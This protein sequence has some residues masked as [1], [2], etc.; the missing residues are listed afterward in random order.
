MEEILTPAQ[1]NPET[2]SAAGK[3]LQHG[4]T[5]ILHARGGHGGSWYRWSVEFDGELVVDRSLNPETDLARVLAA[6]GY[7]G[8][9]TLLDGKTGK[10]RTII[11]IENA[12]KV[13]ATEG[14]SAP[15]FVKYRCGDE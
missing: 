2:H 10:P 7:S 8:K 6:R 15:K 3:P 4:L 9:V 5:A 12:A 11:T 1:D 14:P 13:S